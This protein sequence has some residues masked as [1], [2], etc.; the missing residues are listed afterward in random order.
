M[1]DRTPQGDQQDPEKPRPGRLR[2]AFL[3]TAG[4]LCI[5]VGILLVLSLDPSRTL[6]QLGQGLVGIAAAMW[7]IVFPDWRTLLWRLLGL[8]LIVLGVRGLGLSLVQLLKLAVALGVLLIAFV[9]LWDAHQGRPVAAAFSRVGGPT[10][11]ET[12]I[13]APASGPRRHSTS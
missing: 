12:A 7:R 8:G 13:E 9:L 11:V 6:E 2:R 3:I 1:E 5:A 4:V 10:R